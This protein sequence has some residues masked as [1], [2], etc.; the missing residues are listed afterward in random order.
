M[1]DITKFVLLFTTADLLEKLPLK[2]NAK[3]K[4]EKYTKVSFEIRD[5]THDIPNKLLDELT[6]HVFNRNKLKD[7]VITKEIKKNDT[8][9]VMYTHSD[10]FDEM[11][12]YLCCDS[13]NGK[14]KKYIHYAGNTVDR[15]DDF[16]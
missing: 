4:K 14:Y 7:V 15:R 12:Q 13:A 2:K 5:S 16:M 8:I 10:G 11:Y 1:A 6:L 3:R 9:C